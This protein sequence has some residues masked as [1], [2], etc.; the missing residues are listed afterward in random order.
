[1][2][3]PSPAMENSYASYAEYPTNLLW[4]NTS[5]FVIDSQHRKFE[6]LDAAPYHVLSKDEVRLFYMDISNGL[7][8]KDGITTDRKLTEWLGIDPSFSSG[9]TSSSVASTIRSSG[10]DSEKLQHFLKPDPQCRVVFLG[11]NGNSRDTLKI[12]K[13]MLAKI[14]TF[15]Q[16]TPRYLEFLDAFGFQIQQKNLHFTGFCEYISVGGPTSPVADASLGRS[17]KFFQL[18]YNLKSTGVDTVRPQETD[19]LKSK[20]RSFRQVAVHH[21][22]DLENGNSFWILTHGH[23]D[24]MK[25]AADLL[26][27]K[28]KAEDKDF[29][30]VEA[31]LK[32]SLAMHLMLCRWASETWRDC[33]LEL[34]EDVDLATEDTAHAPFKL[35]APND[36]I[37]IQELG[38]KTKDAVSQLKDNAGRLQDLADFYQRLLKDDRFASRDSCK[39]AI[40]EFVGD[41][42]YM[43]EDTQL[44]TT[45]AELLYQTTSD[46]KELANQ[47]LQIQSTTRMERMSVGMYRE[48]IAMRVLAVVSVIYLP[49]SF[50]SGFFSTDVVKYQQGGGAQSSSSAQSAPQNSSTPSKAYMGSFSDLALKRWLEVTLPLTAVTVAIALGIFVYSRRRWDMK[51]K[52]VKYSLA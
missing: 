40:D 24:V 48:T 2:P 49:G 6:R 39:S 36:L 27:S 8:A 23:W 52:D 7:L 45:R 33:L 14:L 28:G 41:L 43:I 5:N 19:D 26:G 12:T 35:L 13:A 38:E 18:C 17:G 1:M 16:V 11:C 46:R 44:R 30:S 32:S 47:R 10:S 15:H 50:V 31:S 34:E 3:Q 37:K 4:K 22:F 9:S 25:E 20:A 42:K 29:R 21:Q 51:R